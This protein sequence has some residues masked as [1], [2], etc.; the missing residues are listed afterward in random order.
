M[1]RPFSWR[2]LPA[3][4]RYRNSGLFLD[5]AQVLTRGKS[6]VP[7]GAWLTS[8]ASA[9][10]LHTYV[11][12][13]EG[14]GSAP[15]FVQVMHSAGAPLARLTYLAPEN[16]LQTGN[17]PAL[18]DYCA[19]EIGQSGAF[20]LLAEVNEHSPAFRTLHESGFAI[21]ARQR[22]WRMQEPS[23]SGGTPNPWRLSNARDQIGMRSLYN[24][25]VPGLVQQV[26]PLPKEYIR[27][28]V[29]DRDGDMLAYVDLREGPVGIWAQPFIHPDAGDLAGQ[30][31]NLLQHISGRRGRPVYLCVRSYQSWLEAAIAES[32]AEAGPPQ[33]VMVRHMARL[34]RSLEP[35]PL[36][37]LNGT[38]AEP[39]AHMVEGRNLTTLGG[40][41]GDQVNN[42][43]NVS[44]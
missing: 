14:K 4:Y 35:H 40:R 42:Q 25:L 15:L 10:G 12:K 3:L 8:V 11:C 37:T 24:N 1:I 21:Y 43:H 2:E 13:D 5:S 44:T 23:K 28:L 7:V 36:P 9:T 33:A 29:Y 39:V 30:V 34:V 38:R 6:L 16:A 20:H 26:E 31:A 19:K 32:G 18:L 22:I 17:W 27:A 41:P